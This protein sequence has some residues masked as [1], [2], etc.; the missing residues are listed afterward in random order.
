MFCFMRGLGELGKM[1]GGRI[2]VGE[3]LAS[4]HPD[5]TELEVVS[6]A[7]LR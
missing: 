1:E 4:I 5:C 2:G 6:W 7:V 3:R